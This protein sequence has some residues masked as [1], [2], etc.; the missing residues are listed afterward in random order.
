[1]A[2]AFSTKS[3]QQALTYPFIDPRWK[4]K[5]LIGIGLSLACMFIPVIPSLFV[6]GYLYQIIHRLIVENGD[7]YLPEWDDWGLFLKDGWRLLCVTLVYYLPVILIF[8]FGWV[9]YSAAMIV[10]IAQGETDP[11]SAIPL[12]MLLGM[13]VFFLCMALSTILG[14]AVSV[15][16][17]VVIGH[18]VARGS[19]SAGFDFI[20]WWKVFKANPGGFL[21]TLLVLYGM[22]AATYI[23]SQVFS[24][25]IIL[26][27]FI[28]ILPMIVNF[29]MML[30]GAA[31]IGAAYREGAEKL[32]P[33]V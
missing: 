17:P 8:I 4:N 33:V 20:S 23:L 21:L 9:V 29:Y 32:T 10:M 6:T 12:I 24:M 26:M 22:L 31:M 13:A 28:F 19:L 2:S 30:V 27:C 14:I 16:T 1:M 11:N 3:L 5:F 15:I 18:T 7:L 25:T